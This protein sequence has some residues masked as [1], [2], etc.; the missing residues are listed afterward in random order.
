MSRA[1]S[2]PEMVAEALVR[3]GVTIMFGLPGGGPNLE[4]IGAGEKVG[5]RFVLAHAETAAA[6]MASTHGLLSGAPTPVLATRGP[7]AASLVNGVAQ[8]TLDRFPLVAITDTVPAAHASRVAHQRLDQRALMAPVAKRSLTLGPHWT[9]ER[10]TDVLASAT[11]WPYG[12]IH[13]D[14]DATAATPTAAEPPAPAV[15]G[16]PDPELVDRARRLVADARRPVVIVGVEAAAVA[17][18]VRPALDGA[19][20]PVLVTYQAV[21]TLPT[22]HP[23]FA[24][25][26]TNGALEAP[27][28]D[29][30]DL[31][32]TI[33]LD[34]VEPIP[35]PWDRPVPVVQLSADANRSPYLQSTVDVVGDLEVAVPAVL[36]AMRSTWDAGAGSVFA[37]EARRQIL[38]CTV[39]S[40]RGLGPVEVARRLAESVPPEVTVTVDAGAHFLAVMPILPVSDPYQLLISNGLA[41]MGF[42]VPAAIG[43]A[44]ARPGRPVVAV[45]GDGGLSM[46]LAEL[47]T[48]ARLELPITIVCFDDAALSLIGV[49]QGPGDGGPS[50][51]RFRAVDYAAIASGSGVPGTV[52]ESESELV[53][54]L[55][56][57]WDRPRLLDV[58][59]DP[60]SYP[61][62]IRAT[63]G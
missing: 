57:G 32:I 8:A 47:E 38:A 41:T 46:V 44:L 53:T 11:V 25:L 6:I 58:R 52:V 14:Y 23:S 37:R 29:A 22:D 42:A 39:S 26:F 34:P 54:A 55:A 27:V 59:L 49:K 48:I 9:R 33:G 16:P 31:V 20:A 61:A 28:L 43:A 63:R 13:L 15:S 3:A 19:G 1:G 40:D 60:T 50:A 4:L 24:G 56:H 10:L 51:V 17:G 62:L 18:V 2:L 21:G 36:A 5:V 7:G 12:A 45:T 30:A 35:A